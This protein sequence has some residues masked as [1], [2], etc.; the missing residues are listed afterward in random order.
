MMDEIKNLTAVLNRFIE[1]LQVAICKRCWTKSRNIKAAFAHHDGHLLE[2][3]SAVTH[4][5]PQPWFDELDHGLTHGLMT[6]CLATHYAELNPQAI[7]R[8]AFRESDGQVERLLSSCILH[9]VGRFSHGNHNHAAKLREIYPKLLPVTYEHDD[10]GPQFETHPLVLADRSELLRFSDWK[11][12]VDLENLPPL[13]PQI[14]RFRNFAYKLA[15][16]GPWARH[17]FEEP[18]QL[19]DEFPGQFERMGE[20]GTFSIEVDE[21]PFGPCISSHGQKFDNFYGLIPVNQVGAYYCDTLRRDHLAGQ[22][23]V[24]VSQWAFVY[25]EPLESNPFREQ[26]VDAYCRGLAIAPE[27]LATAWWRLTGKIRST[28]SVLIPPL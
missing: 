18:Q 11:E 6:A 2:Q 26:V 7:G 4:W 5:N 1:L 16:P 21:S 9:D 25:A 27:H 20:R 13:V 22:N 17:G 19:G 14:D 23:P 12:W 24:P 28:I 8:I 3:L 15:Q 10:P